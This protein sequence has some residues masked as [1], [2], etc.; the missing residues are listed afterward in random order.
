MIVAKLAISYDRGTSLNKKT[1]LGTT[2][3]KGDATANGGIVRGLGSHFRSQDAMLS[4]QARDKEANR[5]YRAFRE[6]FLTTSIDGLY[7]V[8]GYGSAKEFVASLNP[9]SIVVRVSEWEL[10]SSGGIDV[11]E[12]T[13]WGKKIKNQLSAVG[14]GRKKE[15]DR[16]GLKAIAALSNCPLLAKETQ[17]AVKN[18]LSLIEGS[19]INRSEFRKRLE[20]LNVKME[21]IDKAHKD[22]VE[23][24]D[25]DAA[26]VSEPIQGVSVPEVPTDGGQI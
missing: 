4:A 14:L 23:K 3:K 11:E 26:W 8:P 9:V 13:A 20:N 15:I 17:E 25:K 16:G 22:F 1:D 10:T 21:S 5:I 19:K 6:K 7:I 18:L 12:L 24:A 2:L